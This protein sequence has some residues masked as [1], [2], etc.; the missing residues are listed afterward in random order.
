M[1]AV[2]ISK[3]ALDQLAN[4][5]RARY[6]KLCA[7]RGKLLNQGVSR[8]EVDRRLPLPKRRPNGYR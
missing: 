6:D 1:K 3:E 5:P 4:M 8:V 2:F 7:E